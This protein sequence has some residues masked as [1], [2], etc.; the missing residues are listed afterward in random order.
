METEDDF[1]F[2]RFFNP[3]SLGA[4]GHATVGADFEERAHAPDIIPPGAAWSRTQDG[5]LFFFGVVPGS[6]RGLAQ[7]P[8]N[9]PEHYDGPAVRR[10]AG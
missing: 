7:F 10:S 2:G 3:Q 1:G 4:D 6:W 5:A 8:M 9:F